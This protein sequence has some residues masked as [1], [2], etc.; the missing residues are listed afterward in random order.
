EEVGYVMEDGSPAIFKLA[1]EYT[2]E[3]E[4]MQV[5]LPARG[6]SFDA[7]TYTLDTIQILP[8]L[9]AGRS[10]SEEAI[11][12]DEGYN[13]IPDGSGATIAFD[14][15][16]KYTQVSGT[17]YGS[18]FGFYTSATPSTASYQIWRA[19]VYGTVMESKMNI[20]R[21]VLDAEG[22]V[23]KDEEGN[24]Q[25]EIA[26]ERT[27]K[28]GYVAFITEGESLTRIDAISGTGIHEYHAVS[29]TFFAR[30]TD[31]Y[32]LDGITVSGGTAVY[33]KA[34]DRKYVGN[35]TIKYRMLQGDDANYVGMANTYRAFLEKNGVLKKLDNED[36]NIKLYMD[37]LGAID[38]TKTILGVPVETKADLTTFEDAK[39]ILSELKEAGVSSQAIRYLGWM[40]GGMKSTVPAQVKVV[41]QLG[42]KKELK[43][44]ISYV[45]GEGNDIYLDLN[46]S[47][48]NVTKM[49][50]GYNEKE[51]AAKTIDGNAAYFQTYN[52]IVQ[53]YN[54]QVAFVLSAKTI[55]TYYDKIAEKYADLF[56]EGAKTVSVG[57]LGYALNSSQDEDFPLNREDAKDYT[58]FGLENIKEDFDSLLVEKGNYYTWQ[59]ADTVLDIPLDS[60]NRNTTT[61]EVPFLGILLH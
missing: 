11:R 36:E 46:F 43:D 45:Q 26:E 51:D 3:E 60:S 19:P 13:F 8:F 9:G 17:L 52:P 38:T 44:L 2:L 37:L 49:F 40:N 35:Y 50:D 41:K 53:A 39:T 42:S 30:Q 54:T 28:Q 27:A 32:P 18:D 1:L 56:G 59:Y 55:G 25:R 47:Y 31:S 14:Q 6:I 10:G 57:T 22:N 48:T 5:R 20:Y 12:S 24:V 29:T 34:I 61:A 15:N 58:V 23:V 16:K 33:T 4:G 7:S 21:D